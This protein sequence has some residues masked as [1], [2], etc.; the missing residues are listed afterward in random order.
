MAALG[1]AGPARRRL[2]AGGRLGAVSPFTAFLTIP[3]FCLACLIVLPLRPARAARR[4]SYALVA[5]AVV[6]TETQIGGTAPR[7]GMLFADRCCL[8]HERPARRAGAA[9]VA[10][11]VTGFALLAYWQWTSAIRDIDKALRDPAAADGLLRAAE[12]VPRHG[13]RSGTRWRS[14]V[15]EQPLGERRGG[16]ESCRWRQ[17][18]LRQLDTGLNPVFYSGAS[19]A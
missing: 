5:T 15:H 6:S 3:I 19:T 7:L 1:A 17:G 10:V 4:R 8:R 11:A 14:P 18:W 2:P 12:R 9:L 16:A 13:V